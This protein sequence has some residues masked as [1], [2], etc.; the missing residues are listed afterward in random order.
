VGWSGWLDGCG[1]VAG[2]AE[3][4]GGDCLSSARLQEGSQWVGC[5]AMEWLARGAC[6][7][8]CWLPTLD[9]LAPDAQALCVA[10]VAAHPP[11]QALW[12]RLQ[13]LRHDFFLL[14]LA[15]H[16][17]RSKVSACLP[18]AHK[19]QGQAG[20]CGEC[21]SSLVLAPCCCFHPCT[22]VPRPTCPCPVPPNTSLPRSALLHA[23][24][25]PLHPAAVWALPLPPPPACQGWIARTGLQ[26]G[27]DFVL[28]QRHPA[29]A[30]SDYTV[31][32]IPLP[33]PSAAPASTS[34]DAS[35]SGGA[36]SGSPAGAVRA[37]EQRPPLGW[38]DLQ[39]S[40]RLSAQASI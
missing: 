35:D 3:G 15:Y 36:G 29:L 14:Y 20:T 6:P 1:P 33:P 2:P 25:L 39:I 28:Y 32:I 18:T 23:S 13:Q 30:H 26:Y 8:C 9:M 22:L 17:F 7:V 16:H 4:G 11:L 27:A 34:G 24:H 31:L 10:H 40:N 38:H 21:A 37:E 5:R 19:Q 12:Q